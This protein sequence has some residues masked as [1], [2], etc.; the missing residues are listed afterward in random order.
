MEAPVTVKDAAAILDPIQTLG[1]SGND[2]SAVSPL[3]VSTTTALTS[4]NMDAIN[5]ATDAQTESVNKH[6][7]SPSNVQK[8]G[9]YYRHRDKSNCDRSNVVSDPSKE[10]TASTTDTAASNLDQ[11]PIHVPSLCMSNECI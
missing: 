10:S 3:A 7:K 1:H 2:L 6:P 9:L 4:D 5:L 11:T 8:G